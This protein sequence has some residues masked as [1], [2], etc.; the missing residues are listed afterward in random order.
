MGNWSKKITF[1]NTNRILNV[2][3][4][5]GDLKQL[6]IANM[7]VRLPRVIRRALIITNNCYALGLAYRS[8]K[9]L[10][11]RNPS[12]DIYTR[13]KD[14]LKLQLKKMNSHTWGRE[15]DLCFGPIRKE[16]R[17][18]RDKS[19]KI[20]FQ[21]MFGVNHAALLENMC[22]KLP[23]NRAAML[24][25][26]C[27]GV[28]GGLNLSAIYIKIKTLGALGESATSFGG[29]RDVAGGYDPTDVSTSFTRERMENQ[30][31]AYNPG[32][33]IDL[34]KDLLSNEI[35]DHAR[36]GSNEWKNVYGVKYTLEDIMTLTLIHEAS[37]VF[38][39]TEDHYY[40]EPHGGV[41]Q[42]EDQMNNGNVTLIPATNRCVMNADSI[43]W[44]LYF[45]G[46][47]PETG[48]IDNILKQQ[49]V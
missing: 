46:G 35:G 2:E 39:A 1:N 8:L 13:Q 22:T 27:I 12:R 18:K 32:D 15:V 23:T 30:L 34:N 11:N 25:N 10:M 33:A 45:F 29:W 36:T 48:K 3:W 31:H 43:G 4:D 17:L 21:R 49:R 20:F 44:F 24:R 14:F 6:E 41:L 28:I 16:F 9:E 37:H 26:T 38:A 40:Y 5:D 42:A 47:G 19:T 7:K